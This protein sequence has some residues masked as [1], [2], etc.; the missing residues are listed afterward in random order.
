MNTSTNANAKAAMT[1][2]DLWAALEPKLLALGG[3][4]VECVDNDPDLER[5]VVEGKAFIEP[6]VRVKGKPDRPHWNAAR[7]WAEDVHHVK[8]V[9]GYA[10]AVNDRWEQHSWALKDGG[11]VE[12][13]EEHKAY[14][15]V[16][17]DQEAALDFCVNNF[18]SQRYS[19]AEELFDDG[20]RRYPS[21]IDLIQADMGREYQENREEIDL[22]YG[23]RN[24]LP[25]RDSCASA[26]M[27]PDPK[28][29][30]P[31]LGNG[32]T[33]APRS[34]GDDEAEKLLLR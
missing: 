19:G 21:V 2:S 26:Q 30:N 33:V 9:T 15:G 14:F 17:L 16:V 34:C 29:N 22:V 5:L 27:R 10:L 4:Q 23:A 12:P 25:L 24:P 28:G 31:R 20:A 7:L 32:A 6:V 13:T 11:L 1:A 3:K 18:L 8:I